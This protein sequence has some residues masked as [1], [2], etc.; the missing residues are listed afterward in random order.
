MYHETVNYHDVL[1]LPYRP[2]LHSALHKHDVVHLGGTEE[3]SRNEHPEVAESSARRQTD[4][5]ADGGPRLAAD[6]LYVEWMAQS[7]R[8]TDS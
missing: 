6:A 5:Q 8:Q 1:S 4:G 3:K 2:L 7:D